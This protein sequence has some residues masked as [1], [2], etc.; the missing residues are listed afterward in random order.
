MS[1]AGRHFGIVP[2]DAVI[3][4]QEKK[5]S[6][7]PVPS[8]PASSHLVAFQKGYGWSGS[9]AAVRLAALFHAY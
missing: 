6:A 8:R 5:T 2:Y 4:D 7:I 1:M 9:S 3:R